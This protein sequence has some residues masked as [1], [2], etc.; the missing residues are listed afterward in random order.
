MVEVPSSTGGRPF[1]KRSDK[2]HDGSN[3]K[4]TD[5]Q[6]RPQV[7]E[8]ANTYEEVRN[9]DSITYELDMVHERTRCRDVAVQHDSYEEGA[10][11]AFHSYKL[12]ETC[13]EE[14]Q[15][16]HEYVLHHAVV[17]AFEEKTRHAGEE[18]DDDESYQQQLQQQ[19]H[20][21]P[22]CQLAFERLAHDGKHKQR[23]RVGDDSTANG[24]RHALSPRYAVAK[25]YRIGYQRM[26]SVH[27]RH[28]QRGHRTIVQ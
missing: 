11:Y 17:V 20:P 25:H 18:V 26:R 1:S 14:Y 5:M 23:Q 24:H 2:Y 21:K 19:C 15:A 13:S 3:L 8:H 12:H 10:K 27:R 28:Q 7:H 4:R 6:Q 9:E 22:Q 16:K